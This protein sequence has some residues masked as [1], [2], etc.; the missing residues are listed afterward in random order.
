MCRHRAKTNVIEH[1]RT[2]EQLNDFEEM[3]IS[4][5]RPLVQVYTISTTGELVFVGRVRNFREPVQQW[6]SNLLV[7]AA[8]MPFM[9][10]K[11]R[12]SRASKDQK[13]RP[14]F[15]VDTRKLKRAFEWLTENN[16]YYYDIEW[17]EDN[18]AGWGR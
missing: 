5:V 6:I 8:D 7:R 17:G 14:P 10:M 1:V 2:V 3:M 4:W 18:E 12:M 13:A 11:P 15:P 9:L 16:P